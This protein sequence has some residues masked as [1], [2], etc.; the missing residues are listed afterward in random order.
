MAKV[1][2]C[3]VDFQYEV[4]NASGGNKAYPS[5]K[6]LK[7]HA[8]CWKGCGIVELEL[9]LVKWVRKQNFKEMCK[10]A[11]SGKEIGK[12]QKAAIKK[13]IKELQARLKLLESSEKESK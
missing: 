4:G 11:I 12:Y 2:M 8:K 9:T 3:G 5:I 13:Q 6:D 10:G 7:E 1:Y